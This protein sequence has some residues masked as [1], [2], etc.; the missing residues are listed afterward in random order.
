MTKGVGLDKNKE[1]HDVHDCG[2]KLE[3]DVGGADVEYGAKDALEN[4]TD[5][6]G[7]EITV[8][9]WYSIVL[10]PVS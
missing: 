2:V 9:P 3:A 6:H 7:I 8:V 5:T 10:I 1:H 4:H